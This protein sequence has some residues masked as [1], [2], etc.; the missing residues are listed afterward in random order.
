MT[1][2]HHRLLYWGL[3]VSTFLVSLPILYILTVFISVFVATR[4]IPASEDLADPPGFYFLIF[5]VAA[6]P[7]FIGA[8]VSAI[9]GAV[10]VWPKVLASFEN[11]EQ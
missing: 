10:W 6:V 5:M 8:I 11:T 4:D 1:Q 7:A 9:I 3:V 2:M